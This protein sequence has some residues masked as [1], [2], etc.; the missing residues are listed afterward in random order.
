M[1]KKILVPYDGS[2]CADKAL[3]VAMDMAK[4]Y[5]SNIILATF[6]AVPPLTIRAAMT[7]ENQCEIAQEE[8]KAAAQELEKAGIEFSC[9][10]ECGDPAESIL[11][12]AKEKAADVIV[13]GSRGLSGFSELLLGS[14][15]TKVVQLSKVPVLVCK[16]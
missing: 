2:D 15:S 6:Q 16:N 10:V 5:N 11:K 1:F 4:K 7:H 9:V 12:V 8:Q 14:V 3:V 13:M